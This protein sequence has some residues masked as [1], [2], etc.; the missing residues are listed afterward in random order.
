MN[1]RQ[2]YGQCIFHCSVKEFDPVVFS[3]FW[4]GNEFDG[5]VNENTFSLSA[6]HYDL[7]WNNKGT[8]GIALLIADDMTPIDFGG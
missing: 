6:K 7:K 8:S 3:P 4:N 2:T 1:R 5:I